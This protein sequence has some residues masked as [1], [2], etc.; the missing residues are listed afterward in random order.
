MNDLLLACGRAAQAAK[1]PVALLIDELQY[2]SKPELA[3]L[4][5]AMHAVN[6]AGR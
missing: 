1:L 6:Q 3:A 4:I 2:V 5:R